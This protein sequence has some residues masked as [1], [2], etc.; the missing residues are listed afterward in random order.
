MIVAGYP[1]PMER[2]LDSNP[3][4][5][6][7]FGVQIDFPDYS[8]DE[9]IRIFLRSCE[10]KQYEVDELAMTAIRTYLSELARGASFGNARAVRSLFEQS[11]L[12]QSVRISQ[13]ARPSRSDLMR[14]TAIDVERATDVL[15]KRAF[16]GEG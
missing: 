12:R 8:T 4:L 14:I 13:S 15:A 5:R 11:V 2:F 7:R 3:G 1:E 6:S 10:Q 9:L 16:P